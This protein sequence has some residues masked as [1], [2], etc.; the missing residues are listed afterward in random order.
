VHFV[1]LAV[2]AVSL[3]KKIE[4]IHRNNGPV[5]LE[6]FLHL[7]DVLPHLAPEMFEDHGILK[8]PHPLYRQDLS[9]ADFWLFCWIKATL[10]ESFSRISMK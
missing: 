3:Q 8:L 5:Q 7:D 1:Q 10:D 9:L 6:T 4:I 2:S